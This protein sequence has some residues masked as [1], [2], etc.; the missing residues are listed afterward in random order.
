M[1]WSHLLFSYG[2]PFTHTVE[3]PAFPSRLQNFLLCFPHP[4]LL[5]IDHLLWPTTA[6]APT[7]K[8]ALVVERL[9]HAILS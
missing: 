5:V 3:T 4:V 7:V 1:L 6:S 8:N 2:T 9:P